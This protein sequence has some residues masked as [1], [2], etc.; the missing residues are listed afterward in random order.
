[1]F[2]ACN[3]G[4]SVARLLLFLALIHAPALVLAAEIVPDEWEWQLLEVRHGH[5]FP[6]SVDAENSGY[7]T[8]IP[9]VSESGYG[10]ITI[11]SQGYEYDGAP[12]EETYTLEWNILS[13]LSPLE[14]VDAVAINITASATGDGL[15]PSGQCPGSYDSFNT[16]AGVEGTFIPMFMQDE[17][18]KYYGLGTVGNI[19]PVGGFGEPHTDEGLIDFPE[20][21]VP[22][23]NYP[24]Y[25]SFMTYARV[26]N[27]KAGT[28]EYVV[29]F[30]YERVR[31]GKPRL[32]I[33]L[34]EL[35]NNPVYENT[36]LRYRVCISNNGPGEQEYFLQSGLYNDLSGTDLIS[37]IDTDVLEPYYQFRCYEHAVMVD[38]SLNIYARL[39]EDIFC[40]V[41]FDF[42]TI[43]F[44]VRRHV[45]ERILR[46][47]IILQ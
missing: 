10:K 14:L 30:I 16:A 8:V 40:S 41:Q 21:Y 43:P 25:A 34:L 33:D 44:E 35:D 32:S 28:V 6:G 12:C 45:I 36:E 24:Q 37:H 5:A 29:V 26:A 31:K 4:T 47:L 22:E 15:P 17:P 19:G 39:C 27:D 7:L 38:K 18:E 9:D 42:E 2:T 1:M 13:S 46:Q 11:V 23:E 3:Q 20:A